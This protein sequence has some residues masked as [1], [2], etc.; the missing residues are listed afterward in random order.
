MFDIY[1]G[2]VTERKVVVHDVP[3]K[4]REGGWAGY[5]GPGI[6]RHVEDHVHRH[7]EAV[8][9]RLLAMLEAREYDWLVLGGPPEDVAEFAGSLHPYVRERLRTTVNLPLYAPEADVA[10]A[11]REIEVFLKRQHD[12]ELLARVRE[13]LFPGGW[14]VSGLDETLSLLA[15]GRVR[16]FLVRAGYQQPGVLC[17]RG[18]LLPKEAVREGKGCPYGCGRGRK[19]ADVLDEAVVMALDE[20]AEV[21]HVDSPEMERLG[22]AAALLRY[23]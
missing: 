5:S 22:N 10:A 13:G 6:A 21:A 19:V 12:L 11:G 20:G 17:P 23:R 9:A 3:S 8:A 15:E 14:A 2:E 7:M 4:V 1:L 18:H 16:T